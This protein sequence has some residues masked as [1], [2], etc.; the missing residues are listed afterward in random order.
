M[1][2][3]SR[4]IYYDDIKILLLYQY[5]I[6]ILKIPLLKKGHFFKVKLLKN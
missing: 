3:I 6:N 4:K 2:S 5:F 1:L